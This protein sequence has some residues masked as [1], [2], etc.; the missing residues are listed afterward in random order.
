M[1][2][3]FVLRYKFAGD[4]SLKNEQSSL[5]SLLVFASVAQPWL[6]FSVTGFHDELKD[7]TY[8]NHKFTSQGR[9]ESVATRSVR[10][11]YYGKNTDNLSHIPWVL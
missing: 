7:C 3:C 11:N 4:V 5:W 1:Y 9:E 2:T 8:R 10:I 6:R